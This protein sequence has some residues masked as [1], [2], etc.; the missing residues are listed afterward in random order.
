M[1]LLLDTH[2]FLW[3]ITDDSR[4]STTIRALLSDQTNDLFL[5][6]ATGIEIAIKASLGKLILPEQPATY[7]EQQL[8][9]N[10]IHALP[11]EM[12]HAVQVYTLPFHHRDPFDRLLIAQC[13]VEGLILLTADDKMKRYDIRVVL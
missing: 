12:R 3:W 4:L 1:K 6:A 7:I 5:S 13:Q 9:I 10:T 8:N 11:I 2:I